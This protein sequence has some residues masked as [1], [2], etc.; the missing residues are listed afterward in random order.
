MLYLVLLFL[1]LIALFL[2]SVALIVHAWCM[3][4]YRSPFVPS[5]KED[6]N[7]MLRSVPVPKGTRVLD[8]G[9]GTGDVLL[10]FARQGAQ[11]TGI[12][13]NPL[14]VLVSW[15]RLKAAGVP[16]GRYTVLWRDFFSGRLPKT[17]VVVLYLMPESNTRLCAKLEAELPGALAIVNRFDLGDWKPLSAEGRVRIYRV[18]GSSKH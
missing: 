16:R 3:Q 9:S 15:L 2:V 18:P 1:F 12:E 6:I 11:V 13:I 5:R 8:L 4:R 14:L 7:V 10:A 17:D